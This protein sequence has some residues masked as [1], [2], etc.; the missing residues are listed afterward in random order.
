M[1][2]RVYFQIKVVVYTEMFRPE[3]EP[4]IGFKINK[5]TN[6]IV[7]IVVLKNKPF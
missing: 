2:N 5:Q 6:T 1:D 4:S 3:T 7:V